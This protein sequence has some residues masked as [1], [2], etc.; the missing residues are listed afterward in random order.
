[1]YCIHYLGVE[2]RDLEP[3]NVLRRGRSCTFKI[4]DFGF[5]DVDHTCP[6][7]RECGELKEVW[8]KLQLDRVNFQF[9]SIMP[10]FKMRPVDDRRLLLFVPLLFTCLAFVIFLR[11]PH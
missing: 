8:R 4:I 1:V 3:R 11:T 7:W 5:S 9:K 2:H 6:G 10:E